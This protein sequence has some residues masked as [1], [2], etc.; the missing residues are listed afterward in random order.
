MSLPTSEQ[1]TQLAQDLYVKSDGSEANITTG[2]S[3]VKGLKV[4]EE[5]KDNPPITLGYGYW[6]TAVHDYSN[7]YCRDFGLTSTDNKPVHKN[8]NS[9]RAVCF[10]K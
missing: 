1:L 4:R 9:I 3:S 8:S 7:A 10:A 2:Y 5:Y 6:Y